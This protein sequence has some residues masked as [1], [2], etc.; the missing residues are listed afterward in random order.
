MELSNAKGK[1]MY[2]HKLLRDALIFGGGGFTVLAWSPI[3]I[4]YAI[5]I[6]IMLSLWYFIIAVFLESVTE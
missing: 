2:Y 6:G 5:I 3:A 1:V 4:W